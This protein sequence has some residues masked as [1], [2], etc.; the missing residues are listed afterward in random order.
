MPTPK[1]FACKQSKALAKDIASAYGVP[2]G[3]IITSTYSDDEF[4]PSFEESVR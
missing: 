2:L 3:N 4:Q 1:I